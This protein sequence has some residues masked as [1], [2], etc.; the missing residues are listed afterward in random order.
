MWVPPFSFQRQR[1]IEGMLRLYRNLS[2]TNN[3]SE[4]YSPSSFSSRFQTS[5]GPSR[6]P[7]EPDRLAEKAG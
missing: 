4:T 3:R 7:V 1:P 2:T 6:K 5:I